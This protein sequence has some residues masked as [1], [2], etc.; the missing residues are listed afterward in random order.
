MRGLISQPAWTLEE[1]NGQPSEDLLKAE[2]RHGLN[3][4]S[5][6]FGAESNSKALPEVTSQAW[7]VWCSS[8]IVFAAKDRIRELNDLIRFYCPRI[9]QGGLIPNLFCYIPTLNPFLYS[10]L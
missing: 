3:L 10:I 1:R 8:L 2:L 6:P 5:P 9:N 7:K 4:V